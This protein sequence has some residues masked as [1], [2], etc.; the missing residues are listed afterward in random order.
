MLESKTYCAHPFRETVLLPGDTL[1]VCQRHTDNVIIDKGF[2]EAFYTGKIQEIRELMLEGK[3]VP[4]C[5]QCYREE[6]VGIK[7]MRQKSIEK[8]GV[9][10]DIEIHSIDVQF[11]N[12]CNLKCRMC[13]S[14]QS[15]LLY[16]EEIEIFGNAVSWQKAT[17]TDVYTEIDNSKINEIVIYGGEPLLSERANKFLQTF[18]DS[19]RISEIKISTPTNGM[20]HPSDTFLTAFLSC[21]KLDLTVSIDAYGDLNDYFRSRSDFDTVIHN[22]DFFIDLINRRGSKETYVR[23]SVTVNVYNVNKLQEL[24]TFL[25]SRYTNILIDFNLLHNPDFLRISCLPKEY[26]DAIRHKVETYPNVLKMLDMDDTNYF[27]EFI[28]YH[29]KLDAIRQES[30]SEVN[31]ELAEYIKNYKSEKA[32]TSDQV[33]KFYPIIDLGSSNG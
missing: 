32:V 31:L 7:S 11:D 10:T 17:S 14:T 2:H 28:F 5:D 8:H 20:V 27:E 15:H 9:V 30:L 21:K 3:S 4:G 22:L 23:V 33:R 25:R 12:T 18:I 19:E 16:N 1:L 29:N 13:A 26:K 6:S 24:E